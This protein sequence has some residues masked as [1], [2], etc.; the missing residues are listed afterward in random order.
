MLD[1]GDIEEVVLVVI[2]QEPVHLRRVHA[3]VRLGDVDRGIADG[4]KNINRHA[5]HRENGGGRERHHRNDDGDRTGEGGKGQ[6][7]G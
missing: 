7:H 4:R 3:A 2:R 1:A 6:A 5:P